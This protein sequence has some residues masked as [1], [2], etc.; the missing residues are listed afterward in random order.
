[1]ELG[2]VVADAELEPADAVAVAFAGGA[3][4]ALGQDLGPPAVALL[5]S[6][7]RRAGDAGSL[8]SPIA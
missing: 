1:M 3:R 4:G 2:V 5:E 6:L 7:G 8:S